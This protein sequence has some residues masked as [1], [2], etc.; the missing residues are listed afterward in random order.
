MTLSRCW[1]NKTS[2]NLNLVSRSIVRKRD[3]VMVVNHDVFYK[4]KKDKRYHFYCILFFFYL[5]FVLFSSFLVI[6]T[7]ISIVFNYAFL[8]CSWWYLAIFGRFQSLIRVNPFRR[9]KECK[10]ARYAEFLKFAKYLNYHTHSPL[11][12]AQHT[13]SYYISENKVRGLSADCEVS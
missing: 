8:I 13:R 3:G 4:L 6:L 10:I 9:D 5:N 1:A 2:A 12:V 11:Y 7:V